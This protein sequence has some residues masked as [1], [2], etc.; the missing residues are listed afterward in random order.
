MV[1][2][3]A[4][5]MVRLTAKPT[6]GASHVRTFSEAGTT[7]EPKIL[8][9]LSVEAASLVQIR[10]AT[11]EISIART[12]ASGSSRKACLNELPKIRFP[13]SPEEL[14]EHRRPPMQSAVDRRSEHEHQQPMSEIPDQAAIRPR[15][16]AP[17]V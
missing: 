1:L 17:L 11:M 14:E 7:G 13:V 3:M 16:V 5:A 2:E 10:W 4:V 9:H 6:M 8:R 15:A 12:N